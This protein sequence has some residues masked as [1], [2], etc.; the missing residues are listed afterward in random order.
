M[1]KRCFILS[2]RMLIIIDDS[3][4]SDTRDRQEPQKLRKATTETGTS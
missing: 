3:A 1:T 4:N 2:F